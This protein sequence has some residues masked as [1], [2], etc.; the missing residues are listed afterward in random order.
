MGKKDIVKRAIHFDHPDRTPLWL[1]NQDQEDG[2]I[3]WYDF[4]LDIERSGGGYHAGNLSE[5][6][7]IWRRLDDGT[8]GQPEAPVIPTWEHYKD[9]TLPALNE[10]ERLRG[11]KAF[12]AGRED[13]YLLP[14]SAI[15]GFTTYTFLRGFENAMID[16]AEES[17]SA[18]R[19]LDDIFEFEMELISLAAKAGF[20]G[21]HFGDDWG[22]QESLI[23]SPEMWRRVFMPRYKRQFDHAHRMGLDV[24]FHTCGNVMPI[25]EDFHEIGVD[26]MNIAQPNTNDMER[27]GTLLRGKQ[28]FLVPISYQTVSISGMVADIHAEGKRLYECLATDEGGFIGY[29]EEYGCMGMTEENYRACVDAFCGL[30]QFPIKKV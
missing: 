23:V 5:W 11:F 24:W 21:Y 7:Y 17:K 22:M 15:T 19:L 28:C 25:V 18:L 3:L 1:F 29:V 13:Y 10:K 27:I 20:D 26:V 16:F 4:R 8:M 2:D 30:S 12:R 14:L 6:G 9:Y